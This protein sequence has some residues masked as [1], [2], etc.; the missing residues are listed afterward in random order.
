MTKSRRTSTPHKRISNRQ[1]QVETQPQGLRRLIILGILSAI[2]IVT[3]VLSTRGW[4]RTDSLYMRL[5]YGWGFALALLGLVYMFRPTSMKVHF[6]NHEISGLTFGIVF[7]ALG[8]AVMSY[9]TYLAVGMDPTTTPANTAKQTLSVDERYLN[10]AKKMYANG[11]YDDCL[12]MLGKINTQD[13]S[14]LEEVQYYNIMAHYHSIEVSLRRYESVPAE[15]TKR[16]EDMFKQFINERPSSIRFDDIQYWI[17]HLYLQL[18]NDRESA[19]R[20]FDEIVDAY[21]H[22]NWIQGSLYY[23]AI[24]HYEKATPVDKELAVRRLTVLIKVGGPLRIVEQG[25]DFRAHGCAEEL[26]E[27][28]GITTKLADTD[29]SDLTTGSPEE[30]PC[31]PQTGSGL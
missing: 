8:L 24:L 1:Q 10:R 4:R 13:D 31:V 20:V 12:T 2:M 9:T 19:L 18:L 3:I 22:S 11:Q 27:K 17:G 6:G 28:W 29:I 26:L 16:L 14:L 21:F 7:L 5:L 30:D 23:S 15:K 25:R